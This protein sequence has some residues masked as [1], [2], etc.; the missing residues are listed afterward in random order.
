MNELELFAATIAL[1]DP[2]QRAALLDRECADKPDLRVRLE[3][4]LAAHFRSNPLL[5]ALHHPIIIDSPGDAVYPA[6]M[7]S[8]ETAGT[9]IAGKYKLL[10]QIGTGGMGTV[11]MADQS[12]PVKRRVAL[13]SGS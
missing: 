7:A 6:G 12:E 13:R 4:L 2:V 3:E 5:D 1:T 10:Q 11:W 8:A 9:V